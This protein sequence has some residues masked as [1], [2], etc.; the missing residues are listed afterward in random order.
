MSKG[1]CNKNQNI[2]IWV[3]FYLRKPLTNG[4]CTAIDSFV[5]VVFLSCNGQTKIYGCFVNGTID[6]ALKTFQTLLIGRGAFIYLS[7]YTGGPPTLQ[8]EPKLRIG[9]L[10]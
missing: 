3:E 1:T 7:C 9:L 8:G 10:G 6:V 5:V 2:R 4:N